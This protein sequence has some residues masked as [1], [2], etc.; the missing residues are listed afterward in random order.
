MINQLND[1]LKHK[2]TSFKEKETKAF[3]DY[4][5][6]KVGG[7]DYY[8]G[9][10]LNQLVVTVGYSNA[11][12]TQDIMQQE[13]KEALS[14][15]SFFLQSLRWQARGLT[16]VESITKAICDSEVKLQFLFSKFNREPKDKYES[17]KENN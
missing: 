11:K 16:I 12:K 13:F 10:N 6:L 9:L 1:E 8:S 7:C 3:K 5:S 14:A 15:R 17:I 4:N 2:L